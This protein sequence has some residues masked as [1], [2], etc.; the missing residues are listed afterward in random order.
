MEA[1]IDDFESRIEADSMI[2]RGFESV[3]G[4]EA[5]ANRPLAEEEG[6]VGSRTGQHHGTIG[7]NS[8]CFWMRVRTHK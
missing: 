8:R 5:Y 7:E 4:V 3:H 2:E 1:V 6:A